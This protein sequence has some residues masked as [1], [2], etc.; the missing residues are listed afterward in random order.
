M[1]GEGGVN[2]VI[3]FGGV[4]QWGEGLAQA[5]SGEQTNSRAFWHLS[6]LDVEGDRAVLVVGVVQRL[7]VIARPDDALLLGLGQQIELVRAQVIKFLA[8]KNFWAG[9]QGIVVDGEDDVIERT[10]YSLLVH[11]GGFVLEASGERVTVAGRG[12]VDV[13]VV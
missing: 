9:S 8:L 12:D 7:G 2:G 13:A 6:W 5:L 10:L 11:D 1:G 3:A 4:H